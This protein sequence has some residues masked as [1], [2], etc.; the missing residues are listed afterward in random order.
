M[1]KCI[2][3]LIGRSLIIYEPNSEYL[4]NPT[5][6]EYSVNNASSDASACFQF[7]D[8]SFGCR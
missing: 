5:Q 6:A 3:W 1:L 7:G 2:C 8:V 4:H